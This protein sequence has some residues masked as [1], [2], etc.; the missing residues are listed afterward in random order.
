[1]CSVKISLM[2]HVWCHIYYTIFSHFLY[3]SRLH[4]SSAQSFSNYFFCGHLPHQGPYQSFLQPPSPTFLSSISGRVTFYAAAAPPVELNWK[5]RQRVVFECCLC[6]HWWWHYEIDKN[7]SVFLFSG[8]QLICS[9]W[10]WWDPRWSY[11]SYEAGVS[12]A[13]SNQWKPVW[14]FHVTGSK[15]SPCCFVLL[16]CWGKVPQS[17]LE[18]PSTD[19]RLYNGLVQPLAKRCSCGRY[20]IRSSPYLPTYSSTLSSI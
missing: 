8:V 6:A 20:V 5:D 13:T 1:M 15:E 7:S 16:T 3:F 10:D 12:K 11:P 9:R 18:V 4:F 14:V 19:I 2:Q 17:G